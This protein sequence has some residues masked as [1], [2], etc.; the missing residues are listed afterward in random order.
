MSKVSSKDRKRARL[1]YTLAGGVILALLTV[2]VFANVV[3]LEFM[4]I[5]HRDFEG[6]PLGYFAVGSTAWWEIF[7]TAADMVANFIGDGILVRLNYCFAPFILISHRFTGATLYGRPTGW[8]WWRWW[9]F[10]SALSV[11]STV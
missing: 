2:E 9:C 5:D 10:I 6:G 7:G 4:W 8:L 11:I 1:Y 3:L